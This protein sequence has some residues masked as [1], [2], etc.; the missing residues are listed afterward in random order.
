[1]S[2]TDMQ[3]GPL[4]A[5]VADRRMHPAMKNVLVFIVGAL[6]GAVCIFVFVTLHAPLPQ[7]LSCP[8]IATAAIPQA[9]TSPARS[10]I[11]PTDPRAVL[12]A[13][14]PQPATSAPTAI[15]QPASSPQPAPTTT[16]ADTATA[17]PTPAFTRADGSVPA[18]LIP[19]A[20]IKASQLTDTYTDARSGGRIHDAI[21]IMAPR[22]TQVIAADD[23]T[24]AKL[25]YSKQGGLTVYE[26]DPS[27]KF[28]YYY[29]HL[30]SYAPGLAEGKQLHRGDPIGLVGFSGNA[31]ESAPHL[32]FAIF[33][34][35]SE[36]RWWQGTAINPYPVLRGH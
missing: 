36:K 23:G 33:V 13:N 2:S 22:D 24:I 17:V 7:T 30:D 18:L 20:G 11:A 5:N 28:A 34:L 29:A 10:V 16:P 1:M 12:P 15:A 19:V 25:F 35:G 6:F 14:A 32:H 31:S 4:D 9:D 8:Q 21:D 3:P 27:G 26:F